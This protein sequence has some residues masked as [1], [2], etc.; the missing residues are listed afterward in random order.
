MQPAQLTEHEEAN[1]KRQNLPQRAP[2]DDSLGRMGTCEEH[3]AQPDNGAQKKHTR[4]NSR[5]NANIPNETVK[6]QIRNASRRTKTAQKTH[7]YASDG[8]C[9]LITALR[10]RSCIIATER[11]TTECTKCTPELLTDIMETH[12]ERD[13]VTPP[14]ASAATDDTLQRR[15]Q[16]P[17]TPTIR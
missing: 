1:M 13:S 10:H 6:V 12:R 5:R 11:S 2:P 15:A 14:H 8:I 3:A 9:K 7:Q 4:R 16:V 17:L